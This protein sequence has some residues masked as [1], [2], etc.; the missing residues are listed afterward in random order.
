MQRPVSLHTMQGGVILLY[1]QRE[2]S[3]RH[4]T[5]QQHHVAFLT[6]SVYGCIYIGVRLL[7]SRW[8]EWVAWR[9]RRSG[10]TF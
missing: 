3:M 7:R 4:I 8:I 5:A 2:E 1:S 10:A 6:A 9:P